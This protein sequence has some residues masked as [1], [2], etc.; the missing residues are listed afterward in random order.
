MISTVW[1]CCAGLASSCAVS[2]SR[3]AHRLCDPLEPHHRCTFLPLLATHAGTSL[4]QHLHS[5]LQSLAWTHAAIPWFAQ[6]HRRRLDWL[7]TSMCAFGQV[8]SLT[9]W[10][11]LVVSAWHETICQITWHLP[12][13]YPA[14]V[15]DSKLIFSPNHFLDCTLTPFSSSSLYYFGHF[16]ILHWLIH[17]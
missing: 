12:S 11:Y 4:V 14:S 6:L 10:A 8:S 9:S 1:R 15:S 7:S 13:R 2:K 16:Q 3:Q 5:G 17:L